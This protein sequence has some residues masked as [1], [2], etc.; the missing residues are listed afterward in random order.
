VHADLVE[1][2]G[3]R[4]ALDERHADGALEHA[5]GGDRGLALGRDP[6]ELLLVLD[7]ED[8]ALDH[9]A[10]VGGSF[11]DDGPVELL[12]LAF[13]EG[14]AH[15]V[16]GAGAKPDEEEAACGP[17]QPVEEPEVAIASEVLELGADSI[18][19]E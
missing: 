6:R 16:V 7:F 5:V 2:P 3:E 14:V 18:E 1:A 12:D 8:W 9:A 4:A 10:V 13:G 11:G 19:G 15:R 17:V